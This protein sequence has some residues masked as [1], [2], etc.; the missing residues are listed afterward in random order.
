MTGDAGW[1]AADALAARRIAVIVNGKSRR[2][3]ELFRAACEGLEAEGF[4]LTA[5]HALRNPRLLG[6]TLDRVIAEGCDVIA[7]GGGDGTLAMAAG[8]LAGKPILMAVLPFGTANSFA[9]TLGIAP[10]VGP[11]VAVIADGDVARA[12]VVAVGDTHFIN[13]ATIGVPAR[14]AEDIPPGLKRWF[15]RVGYLLYGCWKFLTLKSFEARIAI[16]GQADVVEQVLEIRVGNG[17]FVGGLRV[18]DGADPESRDVVIQLV[19]GRYAAALAG[20]WAASLAGWRPARSRVRELRAQAFTLSCT[21]EQPLSVD[22]ETGTCTPVTFTVEAGALHIIVPKGS[23]ATSR[24]RDAGTG[25]MDVL[26]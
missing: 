6:T 9:R 22:G 4:T 12:D 25:F 8:K 13:S 5:A 20:V 11:A 2:G 23:N 3:R 14:I 17:A 15:G 21:P 7:V 19:R 1:S 16:D 10:E 24:T 26:D 18:I